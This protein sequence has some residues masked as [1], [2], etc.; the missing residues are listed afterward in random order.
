[1]AFA[2]GLP[3]WQPGYPT[4]RRYRWQPIDA[5]DV[6]RAGSVVGRRLPRCLGSKASGHIASMHSRMPVILAERPGP[7]G[8]TGLQRSLAGPVLVFGLIGFC[9]VTRTWR[10]RVGCPAVV[11]IWRSHGVA[12]GSGVTH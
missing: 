4:R 3:P 2:P 5:V 12:R 1:M 10:W 9:G 6:A 8:L 7:A 11:R